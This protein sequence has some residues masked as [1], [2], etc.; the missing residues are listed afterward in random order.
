MAPENAL[1]LE[2]SVTGFR[3]ATAAGINCVV[4]PDHFIPKSNDAFS[5]AALIVKSLNELN[6]EILRMAHANHVHGHSSET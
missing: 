3:A 6:P 2:D 4:C 1:A 5:G